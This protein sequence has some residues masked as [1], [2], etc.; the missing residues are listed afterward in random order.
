MPEVQKPVLEYAAP[1]ADQNQRLDGHSADASLPHS[2]PVVKEVTIRK[3]GNFPLP[4]VS[5]R[6]GKERRWHP[7]PASL[8]YAIRNGGQWVW[9][10]ALT[11]RPD[12]IRVIGGRSNPLHPKHTHSFRRSQDKKSALAEE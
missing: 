8:L 2:N 4:P 7:D 9:T 3:T 11:F 10:T 12:Q 6:F 1:K 5:R